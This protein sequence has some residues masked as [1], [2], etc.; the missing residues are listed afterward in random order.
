MSSVT[1]GLFHIVKLY[2]TA[3]KN[4]SN[5]SD[6]RVNLHILK[7]YLSFESSAPTPRCLAILETLINSF[8]DKKD[9]KCFQ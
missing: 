2:K 5:V 3:T 8:I 1:Y 6:F 9:L 4:L 7:F